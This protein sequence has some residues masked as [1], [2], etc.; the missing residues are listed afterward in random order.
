MVGRMKAGLEHIID[1]QSVQL[2]NVEHHLRLSEELTD[3]QKAN[4]VWGE[5]MRDTSATLASELD[6]ASVVAG[7]VSSKLDKVNQALARVERASSVLS[8]LFVLITIP[9]QVADHLHLRLLGVLAL[10]MLVLY[11]WKPRKYS[12]CLFAIYGKP[13]FC[14]TRNYS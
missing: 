3:A 12:L 4:L 11:F 8:T 7:R 6:S 5:R 2:T 14:F 10:P 1:I 9:S 13:A